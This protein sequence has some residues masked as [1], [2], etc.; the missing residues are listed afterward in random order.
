[1][2]LTTKDN[3]LLIAPKLISASDDLWNLILA[4]VEISISSSVFGTKTEMAARNWV[5]HHMTY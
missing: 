5:A 3:V 1:M 2:A 4:D